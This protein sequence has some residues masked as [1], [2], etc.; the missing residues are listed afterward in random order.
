MMMKNARTLVALLAGFTLIAASPS[1]AAKPGVDVAIETTSGTIVV[2]LDTTAAPIT[3]KNFLH[4]VD[5]KAYDGASFYRTVSHQ[6]EPS[7]AIEVIQG[8]LQAG[9]DAHA[10]IPVE[11]TEKTG[12]HNDDG[13]ISMA[14]KADPNSATSEFFICIGD[15]TFLDSQKFSDHAGYAAFGH[16]IRGMDVVLKINHAPSNGQALT[17][18][19][20]IVHIRRL[21]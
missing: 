10:T 9:S 3:T 4:L 1:P 5:T 15:N 14:R 12:L 21:R 7:S 17:P 6:I 20:K 2:R 11:T 16:V 19:V 8:G 18:F 13:A